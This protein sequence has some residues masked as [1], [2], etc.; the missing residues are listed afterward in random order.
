M[1]VVAL[2]TGRGNNTLK[3]KNILPILCKPVVY[4]PAIAAKKVKLIDYFFISSD[5]EKI[6]KAVK[7]VGYLP[8]KRPKELARPDTKHIDVI[9]HA[10]DE[11]TKRGIKIDILIVLLANSP[12]VKSKW[13]YK[14]IDI[15]L[16][17]NSISSVVPVYQ[18]ND[19]HPYRAK[20]IVNGYLE[21]W[22]DLEN[23]E[24]ST[25]RQELEPNYFLCHNFWIL[26]VNKSLFS[27]NGQKPWVFLGNK[28]KPLIVKE[29]FDIHLEEDLIRAEKWIKENNV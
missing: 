28:I 12:T 13:I 5:D 2:I 4:Y 7:D 23:I 11:I 29:C 14:G 24:V 26:N 15:I 18:N 17:D 1:S 21:S 3:D 20:K 25:N 16:K 6:L 10:Y 19:H 8:I 27:K 22:C 9:Y